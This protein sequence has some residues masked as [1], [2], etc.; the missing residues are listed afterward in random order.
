M[1]M[2]QDEDVTREALHVRQLEFRGFRRSDGLFEI[3]GQLFDRK[4]NDDFTPPSGART[5]AAGDAIH[6][7][8][9]RLVFDEDLVIRAVTTSL[10]AFPYRECPGGG[11]SLQGLVGLRIAAG[12]S[13]EVR[14]R[15]PAGD[16]CAHLRE[17]LVPLASAAMQTMQKRRLHLRDAVDASGRPVKIDSCHAYGASRE[18]VMQ[19]WPDFHRPATKS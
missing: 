6:D 15:L 4:P 9:L 1:S 3:E 19:L 16:T 7:I 10:R 14:K 17:I 8:G 11:D 13:S 2:P 5:V 12:W 18:L